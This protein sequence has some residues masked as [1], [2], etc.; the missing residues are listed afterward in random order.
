MNPAGLNVRCSHYLLAY[1]Q[2]QT[3]LRCSSYRQKKNELLSNT[4]NIQINLTQLSCKIKV[5][6]RWRTSLPDS[7]TFWV[8]KAVKCW[9]LVDTSPADK[10]QW[11][12]ASDKDIHSCLERGFPDVIV[13]NAP[14]LHYWK[15]RGWCSVFPVT[16]PGWQMKS[17]I[18]HTSNQMSE[19]QQVNI[20]SLWGQAIY[21]HRNGLCFTAQAMLSSEH[22]M[23][24]VPILWLSVAVKSSANKD[25]V[26]TEN[27]HRVTDKLP[28]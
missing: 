8:R 24:N 20:F 22:F 17:R 3:P 5:E 7:C 26:P 23:N 16:L 6:N 9:V 28:I 12:T 27:L 4:V 10:C 1:T 25:A 19:W 11:Y 18:T 14:V 21:L 15:K 13:C 2:H